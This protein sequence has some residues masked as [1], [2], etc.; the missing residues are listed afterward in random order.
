MLAF[1]V[2]CHI[3]FYV[4][5]PWHLPLLIGRLL[6]RRGFSQRELARRCEF[7]VNVV[8]E[9]LANQRCTPQALQLLTAKLAEDEGERYALICAHLRD[10]VVRCKGDPAHVVIRH[11]EGADL[12][13][14]DLTAEMNAYIGV[15]AREVETDKN[16]AGVIEGIASV[17]VERAALRA[18]AASKIT[19]FPIPVGSNPASVGDQLIAA[20][21]ARR[22]QAKRA[23]S[24]SSA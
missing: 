9:L 2:H 1:L 21:Q 22:V 3:L 15:I 24:S 7:S 20:E 6:E 16:L 23:R 17:L 10:E 11:V 18:D 8:S 19:P 14:L 12:S 13:T 4:E 5:Q